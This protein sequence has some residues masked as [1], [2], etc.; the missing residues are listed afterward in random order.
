MPDH[1][2]SLSPRHPDRAQHP[3]LTRPFEHGQH[4]R[5]HD[6]EQ[7]DDHGQRQQHVEQ[8]EDVVQRLLEVRLE[9]RGGLDLRVRETRRRRLERLRVRVAHAAA[10]VEEGHLVLGVDVV[11]VEERVRDRHRSERRSALREL[12]DPLDFQRQGLRGRRLERHRRPDVQVVFLRELVVDEGAVAAELCGHRI[13]AFLPVE[14]DHPRQLRIGSRE[15]LH[16]A[17]D[18]SR[19]GAEAGDG[20]DVRRLPH[21]LLGGDRQRRERVLGGERVV[22]LEQVVDCALE[23]G[24]DPLAEDGDERD[25]REPDHEG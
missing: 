13:R 24:A 22:A 12:E 25:E 14:M 15:V 16:R 1:P 18:A 19:A 3:Q 6:P 20:R 5:V 17:E 11:R 10:R 23:R 2:P 9:L 21:R 7:A 8:A 4:E